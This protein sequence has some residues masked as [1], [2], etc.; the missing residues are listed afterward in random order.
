MGTSSRVGIAR[1]GRIYSVR[2]NYD[3]YVKGVGHMLATHYDTEEKVDEL[4]RHGEIRS[5]DPEPEYYEEKSDHYKYDVDQSTVDF[6]RRVLQGSCEHYYVMEHGVWM[7]G[8]VY[9][10]N[11]EY[12]FIPLTEALATANAKD[13]TDF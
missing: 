6:I 10:E 1:G 3:G 13:D 5:L 11:R 4:V 2:I 7:Y 9:V 8:N 12:T